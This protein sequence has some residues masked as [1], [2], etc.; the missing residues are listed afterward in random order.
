MQILNPTNSCTI[1][2]KP[3]YRKL[4]HLLIDWLA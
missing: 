4:I 2:V 1:R 3:V